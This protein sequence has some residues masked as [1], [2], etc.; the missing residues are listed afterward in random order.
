MG[1]AWDEGTVFSFPAFKTL[2][3]A[4]STKTPDRLAI[5]VAINTTKNSKQASWEVPRDYETSQQPFSQYMQL[6]W[7]KYVSD[8]LLQEFCTALAKYKLL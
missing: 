2:A 4:V 7:I 3:I 8:H 1:I 6:T 5:A